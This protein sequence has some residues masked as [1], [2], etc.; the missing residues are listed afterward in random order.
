MEPNLSTVR[1]RR[2]QIALLRKALD[3]EDQELEIA[4]LVLERLAAQPTAAA[5]PN[6]PQPN[7]TQTAIQRPVT[8][9]DLIIA[10]LRTRAEPWVESS[11]ELQ[12]E[13]ERTHG[14]HIKDSS[15]LPQLTGLK[16]DGIIRRDT[17]NR[18]A[19]VERLNKEIMRGSFTRIPVQQ[20]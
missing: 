9:K 8:Q 18:I 7:G 20:E 12:A 1:A 17:Q 6:P 5:A 13:I 11:R 4:E 19:L 16:D 10:T 3:T 14:V 2:A 15:L